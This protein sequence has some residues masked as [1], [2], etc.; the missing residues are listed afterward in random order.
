MKGEGE[1]GTEGEQAGEGKAGIEAV[2]VAD[3]QGDAAEH[4]VG[5]RR[6]VEEASGGGGS[7]DAGKGAED[8]R[9][10]KKG[11]GRGSGTVDC[12][13]R[14]GLEDTVGGAEVA[15]KVERVAGDDGIGT[16]GVDQQFI[17]RFVAGGGEFVRVEETLADEAR[18]GRERV[19]GLN[20][21]HVEHDGAGP[22][23]EEFAD[24]EGNEVARPGPAAE[25]LEAGFVDGDDDD[26]AGE[27]GGVGEAGEEVESAGVGGGEECRHP[28]LRDEEQADDG[29]GT[30]NCTPH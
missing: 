28:E 23:G 17:I 12:G 6:R 29:A 27:F 30:E 25:A 9:G 8:A 18:N 24:E 15:L 22:G 11:R 2:F 10:Q 16:N 26:L 14:K 3:D 7:G 19:V 1:P 20:E 5:V 4:A 21:H 13:E